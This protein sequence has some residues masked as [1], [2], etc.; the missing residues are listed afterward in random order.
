MSESFK[1][2]YLINKELCNEKRDNWIKFDVVPLGARNEIRTRTSL[3]M[4]P[5]QDGASTNFATRAFNIKPKV[6]SRK[7]NTQNCY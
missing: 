4:P 7:F 6:F 2:I 1:I 5:P 3:R